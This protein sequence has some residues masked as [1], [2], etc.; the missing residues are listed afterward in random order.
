LVLGTRLPV[1][2]LVALAEKADRELGEI[3]RVSMADMDEQTVYRTR[4]KFATGLAIC[5]EV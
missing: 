5:P 2:P 4:R 3:M 1:T